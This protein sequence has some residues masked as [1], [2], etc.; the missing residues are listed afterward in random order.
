M[1]SYRKTR[2]VESGI[3]YAK[4]PDKSLGIVS[5]GFMLNPGQRVVVTTKAG[6]Q[7]YREVLEQVG[8]PGAAFGGGTYYRISE[9]SYILPDTVS[10][11][12]DKIQELSDFDIDPIGIREAIETVAGRRIEDV[13][14]G[15]GWV[16]HKLLKAKLK[17]ARSNYRIA[18]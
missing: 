10:A 16:I 13:T 14:A 8:K 11:I 9:I 6:R 17:E 12:Y 15:E 2:W 18:A 1:T 5:I 4:L 7:H 3:R